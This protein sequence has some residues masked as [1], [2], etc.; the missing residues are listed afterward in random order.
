M[1][2]DFS[3][4]GVGEP[5]HGFVPT[6]HGLETGEKPTTTRENVKYLVQKASSNA[7]ST[8]ILMVGR[9][10][11][12]RESVMAWSSQREKGQIILYGLADPMT[13]SALNLDL[14]IFKAIEAL[15]NTADATLDHNDSLV[16]EISLGL[17][18]RFGIIFLAGTDLSGGPY[19]FTT[20]TSSGGNG[21]SP[22]CS[23]EPSQKEP[24]GLAH[25]IG[26]LLLLHSF[27][28]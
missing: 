20:K 23:R 19:F 24:L 3:V 1:Q 5:L 25:P 17:L 7:G 10:R 22:K 28:P 14:D 4:S 6:V 13:R 16:R 26:L 12:A 2:K 21:A 8:E 11:A 18:C 9:S 15:S 27:S